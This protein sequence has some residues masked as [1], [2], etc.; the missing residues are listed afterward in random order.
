MLL[1]LAWRNIW[2]NKRR[3]IITIVSIAF[4]VILSSLMRSMQLGSYERM[5]DNSVRFLTGYIQIHQKGYW[6]EQVIDNAFKPSSNLQQK[7]EGIEDVEAAVPRLESFALASYRTQTK[8][9]LVIGI[10]PQKE[11]ALTNVEDKIVQGS[12]FEINEEHVLIGTGLAEYLKLSVGDT[13]VLISQG[14]HGANA[15]GKYTVSGLVQFGLPQLTN[16]VVFMPLPA[17][18]YFFGAEQLLTALAIVTEH[19]KH[20]SSIEASLRE[21]LDTTALEV[22]NWRTMMPELVQGIEVDNISGIIMLML[23]YVVIGFGMFGTFLMMTTERLYEFGILLSVGMRR[24]KLQLIIFAEIIM[25]AMIAV[26]AGFALS[27]PLIS[28]F[29][30][31]PIS[32]SEEYKAAFEKFGIEAVYVFS[33]EPVVFTSQAWVVFFMALVLGG[34]PIYSIWK[35]EPVTAMREGR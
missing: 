21:E 24:Y 32:L 8:G 3:T 10:D 12:A 19:P 7:V 29:Y 4:A 1:K 6:E 23:L 27:I 17:A 30:H 31:H 9:A 20:V 26:L 22:M 14:Y 13:I 25:L 2:R 35:L 34:Y 11:A 33:L 15:A 18:Q 5:I 28:Y 16:Q